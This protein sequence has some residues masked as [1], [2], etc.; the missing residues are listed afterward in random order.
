[1]TGA[2]YLTASVLEALWMGIAEAFRSELA[3]SKTSVQAFLQDKNPA[4][5]LV[6]RVHFN[7][8]ENRKDDEGRSRFWRPTRHN[9]QR[10]P[11]RSTCRSAVR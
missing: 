8:A 3:E 7:L 5:H 10:A 2:E 6:G 11:R 4:W 9:C 1:M